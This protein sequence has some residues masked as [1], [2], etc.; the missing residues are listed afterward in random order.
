MSR[1]IL[2]YNLFPRLAGHLGQWTA[3]AERAQRMGFNWLFINPVQYPGFSGSLYAVKDFYRLNPAFI[4]P[5]SADPMED[6]RRALEVMHGQGLKVML[7][8]V[9]NHTSKDCPLI[10]EHPTWFRR[11]RD[12]NPVS[13]SAIDP[14]DARK[15][16]VWGDL[17]EVDNAGSGDRAGLWAYW[18]AMVQFY[19]ELGFDGF[20]CDA[21][22]K[23]PPR[24]WEQL[25]G[26]ARRLRPG[27]LFAAETLGCRLGEVRALK[28][29]GFDYLFNSSKWWNFDQPWCLEQHTELQ[30]VAP[31][32]AFPESHD[33]PRLMAESGGLEAVQKQR[34]AFAAAFSSGV[35]VPIGYEHCFTRPLHV[36]HS[37]P[38]DWEAT[39]H[40]LRWF[41]E[42]I[43]RLKVH[44]PVLG[45]EG[46]WEVVTDL[47][48]PSTVLCK[49]GGSED[50][51]VLIVVN[52]DWRAPQ[53][54]P[55]APLRRYFRRAPQVLRV[56]R[57]QG[58]PELLPD[59]PL[60]LEPAEVIYLLG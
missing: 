1:P 6:L 5:G 50:D 49:H 16:T 39:G 2:I 12:G 55:A 32:I 34:Y 38:E 23:V 13:P 47:D 46:R 15:V 4:P 7:D 19:L 20:R 3:H 33:T 58:A 24:L 56:F 48:G 10:K 41:I 40:D 29:V 36:V 27:A 30:S 59:G 17:A 53:S 31:S 8:L 43:N 44:H 28:G 51:P 11:D 26:A 57:Q 18:T 42:R 54:V 25:I 21:A 45:A 37:S 22:Y 35:M 9:V 14:A 60:A 52:K